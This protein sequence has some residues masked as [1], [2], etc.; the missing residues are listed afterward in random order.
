MAE[1]H[2]YD[3]K[4]EA[5]P[6]LHPGPQ[7]GPGPPRPNDPKSLH[8]R[9]CLFDPEKTY[10]AG[11]CRQDSGFDYHPIELS[12]GTIGWLGLEN[13]HRMRSALELSFLQK[14]SQAFYLIGAGILVISLL[15]AYLISRHLLRP[16][17]ALAKGTREMRK[18]KFDTQVNVVSKDELGALATDFNLMARTLKQYETMRKNWISDISH[19]LRTPVAVIRSKI[20]ALQDGIR[21]LTPGLL[22]SL[23]RD[24][25]GLGQLINDLHQIS[26][27]DSQT[28]DADLK[29]VSPI[30]V[31]NQ[32]LNGFLIRYEQ[33]QIQVKKELISHPL[34][35]IQG[36]AA[37]LVRV[38]SNLLENTLKYTDSPGILKLTSRVQDREVRI[39]LEDSAPGVPHDCLESIF[40][41]LYRVEQSRSRALGGSGLGLSMSQEIIQLHNGSIKAFESSLGG[42]K[43][44][45]DLPA[46]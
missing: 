28:L 37:L 43:I 10:V 40:D 44:Q 27:L 46:I 31:L 12:G 30:S 6:V 35:M 17:Q 22:D 4:M 5:G 24:I 41:R 3:R 15:I 25:L 16:V 23:H 21:E 13:D 19:E 38:F 14:Q 26:I 32:S 39:V 36:D 11:G 29:P 42:L 45:I 9:L 20:E 2:P 1:S 18:F 33:G 7:G 8:R 34:P